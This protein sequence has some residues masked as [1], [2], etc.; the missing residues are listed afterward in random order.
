MPDEDDAI[1]RRLNRHKAWRRRPDASIGEA[2]VAFFEQHVK[3]PHAKLGKVAAAWDLL[4]PEAFKDHTCLVGVSRGTL[5]V[6]VDSASHRFE[7]TT[8]LKAGLQD[9]LLLACASAGVKRISLKPGRWYDEPAGEK[10][11]TF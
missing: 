1:L 10:R 4:V 8:L 3:K 7:L 11:I 5:T 9:Q 6:L 2:A